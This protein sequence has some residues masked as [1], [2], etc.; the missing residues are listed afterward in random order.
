MQTKT[1]LGKGKA[2]PL[3]AFTGPEGS[4]RLRLQD[5]KTIVTWRWQGWQP[6]D[7]P[8]LPPVNIPGTHFCY[9]LSWPQGYSVAGRIMSMKNSYD[10]N[11]NW[12]HDLLVC[13]AVPQPTVPPC[14]PNCKGPTLHL[15]TI[16]RTDRIFL[17]DVQWYPSTKLQGS[18]LT[19]QQCA[20]SYICKIF[21]W[22]SSWLLFQ[23]AFIWRYL[24][25]IIYSDSSNS[26]HTPLHHVISRNTV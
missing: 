14:A 3:H 23:S 9:R 4:R 2:I 17:S 25:I 1:V 21:I 26:S 7:G 11:G 5:F 24:I 8:T 13:S 20:Q 22:S 10:T 18:R 19:K 15:I 6:Y 16:T 12:S